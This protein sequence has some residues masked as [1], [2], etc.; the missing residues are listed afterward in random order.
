MITGRIAKIVLAVVF[1]SGLTL[2]VL[3]SS[4][5]AHSGHEHVTPFVPPDAKVAKMSLSG[6]TDPNAFKKEIHDTAINCTILHYT[7]HTKH[8]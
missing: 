8:T 5:L 7:S 6:S 4:A 2:S 3:F 1:I